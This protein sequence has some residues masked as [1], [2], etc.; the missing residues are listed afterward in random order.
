MGFKIPREG[1]GLLVTPMRKRQTEAFVSLGVSIGECPPDVLGIISKFSS[2]VLSCCTVSVVL[3]H[4][5]VGSYQ[6]TSWFRI[7]AFPL[8]KITSI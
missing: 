7:V 8:Q 3:W 6:Q 4:S 2:S 1:I 5:G